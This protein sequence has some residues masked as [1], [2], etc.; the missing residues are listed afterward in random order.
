MLGLRIQVAGTGTTSGTFRFRNIRL[1][2]AAHSWTAPTPL[3]KAAE[4]ITLPKPNPT[5]DPNPRTDCPWDEPGTSHLSLNLFFVL[6][7]ISLL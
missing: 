1:E 5:L 4:R 6:K 2:R 3:T 7:C